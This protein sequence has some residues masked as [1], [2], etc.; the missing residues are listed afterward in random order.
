MELTKKELGFI[1]YNNR[2]TDVVKNFLPNWYK[3]N[4]VN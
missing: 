3:P 2:S 1:L 4:K